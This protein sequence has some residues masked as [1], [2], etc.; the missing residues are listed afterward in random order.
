MKN[1]TQKGVYY[2]LY[3]SPFYY[4]IEDFKLYFSS[5]YRKKLFIEKKYLFLKEKEYKIKKIIPHI[6]IDLKII[7]LIELYFKIEYRGQFITYN[8][9]PIT[10]VDFLTKYNDYR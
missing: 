4:E 8:N 9:K 5:E 1:V 2:N 10:D 3:D 6:E 7:L